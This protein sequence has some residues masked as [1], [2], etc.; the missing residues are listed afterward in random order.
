MKGFPFIT[1][2]I[3]V[4]VGVMFQTEIKTMLKDIPVIGDMLNKKA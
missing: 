1:A 4:L 3:A 2:T